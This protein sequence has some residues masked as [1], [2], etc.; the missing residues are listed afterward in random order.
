MTKGKNPGN[1]L[2]MHNLIVSL[3][4]YNVESLANIISFL[5]LIIKKI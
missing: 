1:Y 4:V 5:Y 2:T 3:Y